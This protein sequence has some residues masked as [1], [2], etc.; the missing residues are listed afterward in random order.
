MRL[1]YA[2]AL[3]KRGESVRSKVLAAEA[4]RYARERIA[5]GDDTPEQRVELAAV[6]ALQGD[7]DTALEWLG[8]AFEAGYRDYGF[9]ERD[10][11][12]R[13]LAATRA[14]YVRST[15]CAAM[16]RRNASAPARAGCS[17]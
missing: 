8:L 13:P 6:A 7:A 10:P 12:F 4:E 14:S 17:S 9:L 11:L 5:A 1:R 3:H 15:G 16:S 2:Y